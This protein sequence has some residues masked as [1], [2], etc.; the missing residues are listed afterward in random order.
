MV[1]G[2]R[3]R[4][5]HTKTHRGLVRTLVRKRQAFV[6]DRRSINI[7]LRSLRFLAINSIALD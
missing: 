1:L 7:L 2:D 5:H 6:W 3:L 4:S